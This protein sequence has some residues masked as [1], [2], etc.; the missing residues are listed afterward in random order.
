MLGLEATGIY[1]TMI[2]LAS[3]LQVPYRSM[4][5]VGAALVVKYWKE[6]NM[7][8]MNKSYKQFSSVS[9]YIILFFFSIIWIN[10]IEIFSILPL[11]YQAGISVFGLIMIGRIVDIYFG[12]NSLILSSSKKY[13]VDLIFT[14]VLFIGVFALNILFIPKYGIDGAAISTSIVLILYSILRV[15]YVFWKFNLHPF[16]KSQLF[17]AGLFAIGLIAISYI[18]SKENFD[19]LWIIMKSSILISLTVLPI[20]IFKIEPNTNEYIVK[21]LKRIKLLK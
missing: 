17:I 19:I 13:R 15:G 20:F 16:E 12:I 11:T 7:V 4:L 8:E 6:K 21:V 14:G 18:P 9:L 3:A 2:Y 1:T 10:R 5:R